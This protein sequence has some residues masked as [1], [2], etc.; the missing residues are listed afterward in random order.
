MARLSHPSENDCIV[1]AAGATRHRAGRAAYVAAAVGLLASAAL[2]AYSSYRMLGWSHAVLVEDG[3]WVAAS[4]S[5]LL[6]LIT[7]VGGARWCALWGW[8]S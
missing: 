1:G 5:A 8:R 3:R 4:S 2:F 6:G 7:L